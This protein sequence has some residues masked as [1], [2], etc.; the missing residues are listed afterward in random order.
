MSYAVGG[1]AVLSTGAPAD[2]VYLRD[3]PTGA[4]VAS[5]IPD[6]LGDWVITGLDPSDTFEVVARG[7]SGYKPEVHGPITPVSN[8]ITEAVWNSADKGANVVL[9]NSDLTSTLS[10]GLG[11]VRSDISKSSGKWYWEV[12]IDAGLSDS[13]VGVSS[14]S[15]SLSTYPGGDAQGWGFNTNN[16]G[17]GF[18]LHNGSVLQAGIGA[19]SVGQWIGV[20]LDMDNQTLRFY[21]STGAVGTLITGLPAT[22]YAATGGGASGPAQTANFGQ[23]L[24]VYTVPSGFTA[25][26]Y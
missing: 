2:I 1:N 11:S 25:G 19:V 8:G 12:R 24:F 23:T 10:G 15:A 7:A 4:P 9:S 16:S 14:A 18:I 21:L 5:A 26:L 3:W 22:M 6:A 13:V 17:P 20:A